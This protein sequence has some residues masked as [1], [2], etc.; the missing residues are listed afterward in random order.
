MI[1]SLSSH[2]NNKSE[3]V[4]VHES[5]ESSIW[6]S[7]PDFLLLMHEMLAPLKIGCDVDLR[8]TNHESCVV[9]R[10]ALQLQ[11][12]PRTVKLL[13]RCILLQIESLSRDILLQFR[14]Q[15]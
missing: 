3:K 10:S 11:S 5:M 7:S 1:G 4:L 6:Y 13:H 8:P 9:G 14:L 15:R 2:Y 12:G